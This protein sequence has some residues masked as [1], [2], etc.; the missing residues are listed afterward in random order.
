ME[1]NTWAHAA[2]ILPAI[3]HNPILVFT[4]RPDVR[5]HDGH[6]FDADD[7]RFTYEAI[8]DPK[9]LSPRIPDYEPVKAVEVI[10]PLT[11]RLF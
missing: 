6:V 10:D 8:M 9:N 3:E 5:F 11:V 7:V 1:K 2:E 4:L